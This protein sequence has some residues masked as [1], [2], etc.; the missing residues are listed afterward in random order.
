M[1]AR[2]GNRIVP[3]GLPM[4]EEIAAFE[5]VARFLKWSKRAR[6]VRNFGKTDL[7]WTDAN[8]AIRERIAILKNQQSRVSRT[9]LAC[10]ARAKGA[11]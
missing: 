11:L 8:R 7:L 10:R 5:R 1:S 9:D 4:T 3:L 6:E 2:S